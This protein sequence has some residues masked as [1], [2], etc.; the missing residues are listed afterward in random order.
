MKEFPV[1]ASEQLEAWLHV[2]AHDSDRPAAIAQAGVLD[3]SGTLARMLVEQQLKKHA[4]TIGGYIGR[5]AA[6]ALA[7]AVAGGVMNGVY[8]ALSGF[9]I[10]WLLYAL[11]GGLVGFIT[12]LLNGL[13]AGFVVS[14][15]WALIG[16]C[17]GVVVFWL[18]EWS[19]AGLVT[20][21]AQRKQDRGSAVQ[22]KPE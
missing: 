3:P 19:I 21:Q 10:G 20:A 8:G 2:L 16:G 5:A 1:P 4:F 13:L 14:F 22:K 6:G 11:G 17:I 9:V 12:G 15:M 7:G 18:A